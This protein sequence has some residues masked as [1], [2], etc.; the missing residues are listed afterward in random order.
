MY[1]N[2]GLVKHIAGQCTRTAFKAATKY[3]V[4]ALFFKFSQIHN[5]FYA[6]CVHFLCD[7]IGLIPYYSNQGADN[8]TGC[9]FCRTER[10]SDS[11]IF[12][13]L[14]RSAETFGT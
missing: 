12:T 4:S 2:K 5:I 9:L 3:T 11:A 10:D 1:D 14:S 7:S 13:R 8:H 6:F